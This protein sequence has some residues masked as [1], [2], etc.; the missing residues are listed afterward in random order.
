MLGKPALWM[1]EQAKTEL[2]QTEASLPSLISN[3]TASKRCFGCVAWH[4]SWW[5]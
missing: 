2:A 1:L 5:G 3:F 4:R